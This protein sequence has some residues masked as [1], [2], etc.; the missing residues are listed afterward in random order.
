MRTGL[1]GRSVCK[2][3]QINHQVR[4]KLFKFYLLGAISD[5]ATVNTGESSE[6]KQE[7]SNVLAHIK[8]LEEENNELRRQMQEKDARL[9]TISQKVQES[10]RSFLENN[11]S[12]WMDAVETKNESV[13]QD[14]RMGMDNLIKNSAEDNGV[15]QMMVAASA[16][17]ERHVHDLDRLRNENME[18]KS[19][20][21]GM[22]SDP[23][24]RISGEKRKAET[25]GDR[26]DVKP[27]PVPDIWSDF[28]N[29]ISK[30]S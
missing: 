19:K 14:F 13:K 27:D 23:S 15:W 9:Q 25:E 6:T 30:I 16:L 24:S 3:A 28:A 11:M 2:N 22:Y 21:D 17:H 5:H 12:K 10:M 7:L 29:S 20:V 4:F 26:T 18:L 1:I 8:R